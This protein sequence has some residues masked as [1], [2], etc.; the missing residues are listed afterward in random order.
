[1][2]HW[3]DGH[4]AAQTLYASGWPAGKEKGLSQLPSSLHPSSKQAASASA[5]IRKY[6]AL[7]ESTEDASDDTC[8]VHP[9]LK[10]CLKCSWL[11]VE[12]TSL[13][14]PGLALKQ[15]SKFHFCK[16][17]CTS[18]TCTHITADCSSLPR[19]YLLQSCIY[20]THCST[21]KGLRSH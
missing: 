17:I 13:I 5:A 21:I 2:W 9:D 20:Y 16:C 8:P 12:T 1:M 4:T 19:K 18:R 14:K 15:L 11:L 3:P 6:C 7:D 10:R